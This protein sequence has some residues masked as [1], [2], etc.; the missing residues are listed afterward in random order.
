MNE[1]METIEE[2]MNELVI[3]SSEEINNEEQAEE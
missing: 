3:D 1:A 2:Q